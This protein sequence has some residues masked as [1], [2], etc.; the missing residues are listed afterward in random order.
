MANVTGEQLVEWTRRAFPD[1][2]PKTRAA[3]ASG[4]SVTGVFRPSPT[5][6][7]LCTAPFLTRGTVDVLG[8]FSNGSGRAAQRDRDSDARGL[9]LKFFA[10][11]ADEMDLVAMTLALFFVDRPED[12]E[13]FTAASVPVPRSEFEVS[14]WEKIKLSAQLK[15]PPEPPEADLDADLSP[16]RLVEYAKTHPECKTAIGMLAG[17]IKPV[18]LG[19]A[20]YHGVHTFLIVDPAGQVRPIRYK[21]SP[22]TGSQDLGDDLG[23]RDQHYL[24]D[25]LRTRLAREPIRFALNFVM[26]DQGDP[27]DRPTALWP[28]A[29][30][31]VS[32]GT[33]ELTDVVEDQESGER[34]GFNPTRVGGGFELSDDPVLRA[35]GAAYTTSWAD[36]DGS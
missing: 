31:R 17:L 35:R 6:A 5:G 22:L 7:A 19:R 29:R 20:T 9:A 34:M 10:G 28:V 4:I 32:A 11:T 18:S 1:R 25:E 8:R 16:A 2:A 13:A 14:F 12:F 36:R 30:R 33:L 23:D 3:H 15:L 21:W 27:L 26:A 24:H